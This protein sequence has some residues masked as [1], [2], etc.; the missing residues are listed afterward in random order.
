MNTETNTSTYYKGILLESI[1]DLFACYDIGR[2]ATIMND[3][4][5]YASNP[6]CSKDLELEEIRSLSSDCTG[7]LSVIARMFV[8]YQCSE[9]ESPINQRGKSVVY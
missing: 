8:S 7:L 1:S 4:L 3:L 5:F 6:D 2:I 9:I